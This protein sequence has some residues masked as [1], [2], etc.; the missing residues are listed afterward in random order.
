MS[1][2]KTK[3]IIIKNSRVVNEAIKQVLMQQFIPINK[4]DLC[5]P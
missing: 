4:R 5:S 2:K 3:I 1:I